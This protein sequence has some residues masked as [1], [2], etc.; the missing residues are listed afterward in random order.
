MAKRIVLTWRAVGLGLLG[1]VLLSTAGPYVDLVQQGSSLA[2]GRLPLGVLA[3]FFVLVAGVNT[4]LH[5]LSPRAALTR[6]EL[7]LVYIMWLVAVALPSRG[8]LAYLFGVVT[9]PFYFATPENRWEEH[10]WRH[11][12]RWLAPRDPQVI[13]DFY[14]GLP[15]G[16]PVPWGA[17]AV[18]L[19]MWTLFAVLF[20]SSYF[21]LTVLLRR[22]WIEQEKLVFPLA[23]VPLSMLGRAERPTLSSEFFRRKVMWLGFAVAFTVHSLNGLSYYQPAVPRVPLHNLRLGQAFVSA[24]WNAASELEVDFYFS[25]IGIGYLLSADI[26]LSFWF[27]YL[28][29]LVQR[30][31]FRAYGVGGEALGGLTATQLLRAQ[32]VG[33]FAVLGTVYLWGLKSELRRVLSSDPEGEENEP[34]PYRWAALGFGGGTLLMMVWLRLAGAS[35]SLA[36]AFFAIWYIVALGLTRIVSAGGLLFIECSFVTWDPLVYAGGSASLRERDLTVIAFPQMIF[37]FDQGTIQPPYYLDGFKLMTAEHLPARQVGG[38]MALAMAVALAV[39]TYTTLTTIYAHGAITLNPWF[40]RNGPCWSFNKLSS[41]FENPVPPDVG[42]MVCIGLGGLVAAA[43]MA[44]QRNFLWWPFNAVGLL[45]A[46]TW[47]MRHLWFS[48]FLG[49]LS[50]STVLRWGGYRIH[51]LVQPFFGGLIGGEFVAGGLWAVIDALAGVVGH[52]VVF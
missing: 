17:W 24:P 6:G 3:L 39:G 49:W 33:A 36:A 45:M 8:Y 43:L 50:K 18:P 48:L 14:L 37:T 12:P 16:R 31:V 47:T 23:Q 51:R 7:I 30:V 44:L 26:A 35:W 29:T 32:E 9:A 52:A 22:R 41:W 34:L 42:R 13:N 10:F 40:M 46:S 5:F 11:I 21:C 1:V 25:V 19:V 27:F 28:L 2:T 38:V 4:L 15:P 20:L